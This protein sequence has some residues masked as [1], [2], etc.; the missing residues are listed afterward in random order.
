VALDLGNLITLAVQEGGPQGIYTWPEKIRDVFNS[1]YRELGL[2]LEQVSPGGEYGNTF[3]GALERLLPASIEA[4]FMARAQMAADYYGIP[5]GQQVIQDLNN[6]R[7]NVQTVTDAD[8]MKLKAA[9]DLAAG[10]I[11]PEDAYNISSYVGRMSFLKDTSRALQQKQNEI[12]S[13]QQDIQRTEQQ[14]Q[15]S[16]LGMASTRDTYEPRLA[17][18]RSRLAKA[19]EQL[20]VLQQRTQDYT[21]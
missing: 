11:T 19:R 13:L 10:N 14:Y 2:S 6:R 3:Q 17:S 12:A 4:T 7:D 15:N 8:F 1:R 9:Q 20:P 21:Q 16:P 18:L 5:I